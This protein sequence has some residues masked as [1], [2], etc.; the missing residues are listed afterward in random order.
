MPTKPTL[1]HEQ[2]AAL[3]QAIECH[4]KERTLSLHSWGCDEWG[5]EFAP[6][7]SIDVLTMAAALT[8]GWDVEKSPVDILRETY[9]FR[10]VH[11]LGVYNSGWRA[12]VS[13]TL[14]ATGQIIE[15][16]ND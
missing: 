13:E 14:A 10:R 4:G 1:T 9:T 5:N 15:G 2:S 16:I 11:D 7:N 3:T 8:N 6:L 12:G